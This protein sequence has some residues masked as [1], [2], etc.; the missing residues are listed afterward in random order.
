MKKYSLLAAFVLLHILTF[1]QGKLSPDLFEKL[2]NEQIS[3]LDITIYLSERLDIEPFIQ[4][5][6]KSPEQQKLIQKEVLSALNSHAE[7]S[8]GSILKKLEKIDGIE[9]SSIVSLWVVNGIQMNASPEA[10]RLIE[11]WEAIDWIEETQYSEPASFERVDDLPPA[12]PVPNGHEPGLEVINA[13][14]LW[15]LGYTGYG[16]I[17]YIYDTGFERY[18]PALRSNFR[19][20]N[21]SMEASWK[22]VEP[23]PYTC[24]D[25]GTH[26]AGTVCGID[27]ENN[28]TIGVAF[29]AEFIVSAQFTTCE[30]KRVSDNEAFQWAVNP[31]GNLATTDDIPDVLNMSGGR[32]DPNVGSCTNTGNQATYQAFQALNLA[33]II[34]AGNEGPD[35]STVRSPAIYNYDLVHTFAVGNINVANMMI[36][37]SSSRGPSICISPDSS[38]LIKPEVSAPGTDIRSSVIGGYSSFTGTSMASPH[39]AGAYLLLREAFPDL[40]EE[41]ILLAMYFTAVD[42]GV[43]GE[44][45]EYGMGLLD[46]YAAYEYL[47]D[48]GH[49]PTPPVP[50][51]KDVIAIHMETKADILCEGRISADFTFENAGA[52]TLKSLQIIFKETGQ[53]FAPDTVFWQGNLAPD[54]VTTIQYEYPT[55]VSGGNYELQA[56]LAMPNGEEDPRDLNN[57]YKYPFE[58]LDLDYVQ[59]IVNAAYDN[60]VCTG[61]TVILENNQNLNSNQG[62]YWYSQNNPS[63]PIAEGNSFMTPPLNGDFT[64]L[65]DVYTQYSVGK[66]LQN[67]LNQVTQTDLE[68]GLVFSTYVPTFLKSVKVRADQTGGRIIKVYDKEG[69]SLA[70]K[71]INLT[72]TGEQ[73]IELNIALPRGEDYFI[74]I[75]AGRPLTENTSSVNYP[76]EIPN[77]L[78]IT[79]GRLQ[80]DN[81]SSRYYYF[82]DWEVQA[83]SACGH[84][85]IDL[86][87]NDDLTASIA[88]FTQS[89]D[90]IAFNPGVAVQF[91][92]LSEAATSWNWNFNNG[93]TSMEQN[94]ETTYDEPGVYQTILTITDDNNCT[95]SI[96][97]PITLMDLTAVGETETSIK[98]SPLAYPNPATDQVR[99]FFPEGYFKNKMEVSLTVVGID[100]K[101]YA[102]KNIPNSRSEEVLN[103]SNIPAGLYV[104]LISEDNRIKDTLRIVKQ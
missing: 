8:Q 30:D 19:Y 17:A 82:Y 79:S 98:A 61:A 71:L 44:D 68:K 14:K 49:T 37:S 48:Q 50:A 57:Y 3:K 15:K 26:V 20:H 77:V 95:N 104:I 99:V 87:V 97:H 22:G 36:N 53:R 62:T 58:M 9:Q 52:D 27:R 24:G 74:T 2:Q 78:T 42:M 81:V 103:L 23:N 6:K 55:T 21:A 92:D 38:I 102:F 65:M 101:K 29:N 35:A 100:G 33:A 70:T 64:Y 45:N 34:A 85:A 25:H 72:T 83:L 47:I 63:F 75:D 86:E 76:Y 51:D 39:T 16:T 4:Q 7:K 94:P 28:D 41:Q 40:T 54:A 46:I 18:H 43:P 80:E 10:I 69:T 93:K 66:T 89:G 84:V 90:T 1:A 73:R 31:D 91:T 11:T 67:N 32:A 13:P 60:P 56:Q 59:P 5:L 88:E 96:A 12:P